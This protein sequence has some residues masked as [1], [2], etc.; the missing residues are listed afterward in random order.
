MPRNRAGDGGA[1][2]PRI[3]RRGDRL[4]R[5]GAVR[6][7]PAERDAGPCPRLLR[8]SAGCGGADG[9]GFDAGVAAPFCLVGHSMGGCIATRTLM[10]R[11]DFPVAILSAP[12]WGLHLGAA[13]RGVAV[14]LA[15]VGGRVGLGERRMPGTAGR[16]SP[17]GPPFAGNVLT[18]DRERF[19]WGVAQVE[20]TRSWRSGRRASAGRTRR[21]RRPRGWVR[22]RCRMCRCWCCWEAGRSSCR[23]WRSGPGPV[24]CRPASSWNS[25][26][27]ATRSSWNG[28]KFGTRSGR[29]STHSWRKRHLSRALPSLPTHVRRHCGRP[30]GRPNACHVRF[31]RL[32]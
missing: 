31:R 2:G 14:T 17:S 13:L 8:L 20:R 10:E 30:R 7:A 25:M 27:D 11:D 16:R 28:R 5:P 19:A 21:F 22:S 12:M 26:A 24:A 4:A 3:N 1:G 9:P 18:S 6:P 29:R 32:R 15:A 23:R